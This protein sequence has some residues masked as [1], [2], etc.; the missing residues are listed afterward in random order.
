MKLN[1]NKK[2]IK[3]DHT[4]FVGKFQGE[5][6]ETANVDLVVEENQIS[7][8]FILETGGRS[9]QS[10]RRG[11]ARRRLREGQRRRG[12]HGR[13]RRRHFR[14]LLFADFIHFLLLLAGSR[15]GSGRRVVAAVGRCRSWCGRC[16]SPTG[17]GAQQDAA[18]DV[19]GR[20][21]LWSI[22][23]H[24]IRETLVFLRYLQSITKNSFFIN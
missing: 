12:A 11:R 6:L 8:I 18:I 19:T 23:A 13:L 2:K 16:R 14:L 4:I 5:S 7:S 20:V 15:T 9:S 10:S 1:K 21:R 3:T 24:Y 17:F 22:A